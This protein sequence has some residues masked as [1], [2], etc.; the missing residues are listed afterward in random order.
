MVCVCV[1]PHLYLSVVTD[2]S[3][4]RGGSQGGVGAAW[5]E[6]DHRF[7]PPHQAGHRPAVLY[8]LLFLLL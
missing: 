1:C 7:G 6:L 3:D 2:G 5:A 8:Q 4:G